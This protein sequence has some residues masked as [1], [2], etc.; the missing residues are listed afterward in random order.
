MVTSFEL[1]LNLTVHL[2]TVLQKQT[3]DGLVDTI[4]LSLPSGSTMQNLLDFLHIDFPPDALLLAVNGRVANLKTQLKDGDQ[5]NLM[6][7]LSG[8]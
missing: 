7:A 1:M 4:H 8:G 2:H 6:P 5:I 3:E